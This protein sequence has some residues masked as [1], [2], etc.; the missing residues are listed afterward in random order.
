[1][2]PF[3][4]DFN[5]A[6]RLW[7]VLKDLLQSIQEAADTPLNAFEVLSGITPMR[8]L[9]EIRMD[10][11]RILFIECYMQ[12][13]LLSSSSLSKIHWLFSMAQEIGRE[14]VEWI[15]EVR[16]HCTVADRLHGWHW[17]DSDTELLVIPS[18]FPD[19]ETQAQ[20]ENVKDSDDFKH[21]LLM[22]QDSEMIP[23]APTSAL[24]VILHLRFSTCTREHPEYN[25]CKAFYQAPP[26]YSNFMEDCDNLTIDGSNSEEE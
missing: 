12:N 4:L 26:L 11:L 13:L 15:S 25:L 10:A 8:H 19:L 9:E 16:R 3:S 21:S 22:E 7:H 20:I 17:P 6:N 23:N 14:M 18:Q 5:I 2:T 24:V 1:M